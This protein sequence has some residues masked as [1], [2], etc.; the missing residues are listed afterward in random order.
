MLH[1]RAAEEYGL[2]A[3]V[4]AQNNNITVIVVS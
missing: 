4:T 2:T 1:K 3:A